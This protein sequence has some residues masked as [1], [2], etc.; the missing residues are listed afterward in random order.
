[1]ENFL[2]VME[3]GEWPELWVRYPDVIK[4]DKSVTRLLNLRIYILLQKCQKILG[5]NIT[6]SIKIWNFANTHSNAETVP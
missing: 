5:L 6:R 1:M 3:N 4:Y 2:L